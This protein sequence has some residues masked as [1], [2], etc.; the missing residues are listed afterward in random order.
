MSHLCIHHL[1]IV[2]GLVPLLGGHQVIGGLYLSVAGLGVLRF[3][4]CLV[5]LECLCT[6]SHSL[7]GAGLVEADA[8]PLLVY[9]I[10]ACVG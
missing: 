10:L 8:R 1:E 7:Q 9:I 4:G 3:H 6:V 2:G 5:C